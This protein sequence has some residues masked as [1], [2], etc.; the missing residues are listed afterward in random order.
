MKKYLK[1]LIIIS[2]FFTLCS[3]SKVK[4][5]ANE[6][7][8]TPPIPVYAEVEKRVTFSDGYMLFE[9]EM[10]GTMI[11]GSDRKVISYDVELNASFIDGVGYYPANMTQTKTVTTSGYGIIGK[12]VVRYD[13]KDDL[14]N[15]IATNKT[16]TIEIPYGV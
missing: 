3:L 7:R 1:F 9:G 4:V 16:L 11:R 13:L 5:N 14:G 12:I 10:T 15:T 2:M 6:S 8:A